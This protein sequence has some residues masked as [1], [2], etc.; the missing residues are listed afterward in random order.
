MLNRDQPYGD[1]GYGGWRGPQPDASRPAA[2]RTAALSF[3]P[4]KEFFRHFIADNPRQT[5]FPAIQKFAERVELEPRFGIGRK[6]GGEVLELLFDKLAKP[7]L[8]GATGTLICRMEDA[9]ISWTI[10]RCAQP[11]LAD[12]SHKVKASLC[13]A[14]VP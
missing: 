8:S 11:R 14:A 12:S 10:L 3:V 13:L 5:L 2:D 4:C 6:W 7:L 9:I 1:C